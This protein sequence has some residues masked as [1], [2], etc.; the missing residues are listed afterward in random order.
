MDVNQNQE[1]NQTNQENEKSANQQIASKVAGHITDLAGVERIK[2]FNVRQFSEEVFKKHSSQEI[3]EYFTVGTPTTTPQIDD[4]D[5]VW[6]KPWM[7]FRTLI[8]A[9]VVYFLFVQAWREFYNI[10]LVPG[11][12][13]IGS[14][15]VPISTL[16][17][18]LEVNVRKNVSLY[19]VVRLLFVGGIISMIAAL[20]LF[21]V[22]DAF[23]L[24]W[25]G[26]SVAGIVEE[27]AK[28]LALFLVINTTRYKYI[29]NGLLFGAA[30]GTGFAAFESAGYALYAGLTNS[31]P[32][33][34]MDS[35][36]LR[37]MLSPFTHIVWTGMCGAALWK[38]KGKNKF[39]VEMLRDKR[40]VRI[41]VIAIIM[42][43]I[44]NSP[45]IIPFFGKY[46]L[47]G[48]LAWIIVIAL[49]Q[50]GLK[51]LQGEKTLA[52]HRE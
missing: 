4:V 19:Q 46:L 38:V 10:N 44:W 35:I 22:T 28:L 32:D 33:A 15:A 31:D 49:I 14:F 23:K 8:G 41:F 36:V 51:Q 37:G 39:N 30:I 9:L 17:L 34:M 6:P 1:P 26:A 52:E 5:T 21:Q 18:F 29:H 50:E 24:N 13:M 43:M 48:L 20:I 11:M 25:L 42:H 7:F 16:I 27:P 40:F 2:G 45:L 12:I 3:E 47:L